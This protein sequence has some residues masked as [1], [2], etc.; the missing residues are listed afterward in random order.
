VSEDKYV[1]LVSGLSLGS[2][3]ADN[4]RIQ[5]AMDFLTGN[6]G[7]PAEQQLAAH[8]VRVVVA[9]GCVGQLDA[10]AA[11]TVAGGMNSGTA[12]LKQKTEYALQPVK[13]R[14][15]LWLP[16]YGWQTRT[17]PRC[18]SEAWQFMFG[19]VCMLADTSLVA[20]VMLTVC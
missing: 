18:G 12:Y 20:F 9:G 16:A 8:V 13:V 7:S 19:Q 2:R 17:D 14:R 15:V 1:A 11:A 10:M 5:L 6:L 4:F 3:H